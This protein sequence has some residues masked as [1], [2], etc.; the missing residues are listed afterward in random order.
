MKHAVIIFWS[1]GDCTYVAISPK[2]EGLSALGETREGALTEY[3]EAEKMYLGVLAEDGE[4]I[5]EPLTREDIEL[6]TTYL[7]GER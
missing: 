2:L 4:R 3:L 6:L 1:P 7:R 5:P